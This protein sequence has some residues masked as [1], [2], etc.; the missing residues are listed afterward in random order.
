MKEDKVTVRHLPLS[1]A[2]YCILLALAEPLHGYGI[3]QKVEAESKGAVRIGPG[4]L[5]GALT[6]LEKEKLISLFDEVDRRKRYALTEKGR[7]ILATERARL[8]LLADL[9]DTILGHR[10][11]LAKGKTGGV[12]TS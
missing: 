6:T 11:P 3:M 10:P 4:T 5:Y 12:K 9:G 7:G 2:T 8:R 1:E